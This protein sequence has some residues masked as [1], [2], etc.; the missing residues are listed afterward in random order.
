MHARSTPQYV[1]KKRSLADRDLSLYESVGQYWSTILQYNSVML[2]SS[3]QYSS[4]TI[5]LHC[6]QVRLFV[7]IVVGCNEM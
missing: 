6:V 4:S 5:V 1:G 3:V 7:P 2:Y